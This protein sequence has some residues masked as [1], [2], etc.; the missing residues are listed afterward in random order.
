MSKLILKIKGRNHLHKD[1]EEDDR[2]NGG[3]EHVL[4][5]AVRQQE[6]EW[7]GYGTTQT[8]VGNNK[9][10]L[11]GQLHYPEL[12]NDECKSNDPWNKTKKA[13]KKNKAK[14]EWER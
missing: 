12:I 4:H 8:T 14:F 6:T 13:K 7:E 5:L 10:V 1:S 3:Q 9:L 2:D 11:F